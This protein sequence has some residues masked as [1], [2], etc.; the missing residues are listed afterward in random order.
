[1]TSHV[2]LS[3]METKYQVILVR[4]GEST[5]NAENRFT[6]WYDCPL[7]IKGEEQAI[8][9]GR[10][11]HE[12]ETMQRGKQSKEHSDRGPYFDLAFTSFQK[13]AI[14][15]LWHILEQI[16][17]MYIPVINAWE[18]N[19]RHYG[20]LEGLNK[21]KTA[22]KYGQ[23]Q[24]LKWRRSFNTMPPL[25]STDSE[26]HARNDIKYA[27][28]PNACEVAGESLKMTTE[29]VIPYW[30]KVIKPQLL[31]GKRIIIAA[32]GNSLRSLVKYLDQISDEEIPLVNI[33]MGF[34]LI[35]DF[36]ENFHV[37]PSHQGIAPLRVSWSSIRSCFSLIR[38][39][40]GVFS[41]GYR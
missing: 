22:E 27:N 1:M 37:I 19:E 41:G 9:A 28:I 6:G 29:R 25:C 31:M 14:K 3:E 26:F 4:H 18:L 32:H 10:L 5:W 24:V 8:D 17:Y 20:A 23:E 40:L 11:I 30:E 35:Y 2:I 15:T 38:E 21:H 16:D 39:M 12:Y 13:R 34:P 7:S 36:D 33:P